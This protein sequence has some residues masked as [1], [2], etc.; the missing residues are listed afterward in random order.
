LEYIREEH[1][2]HLDKLHESHKQELVEIDTRSK[3]LKK[4]L[5]KRDDQLMR[6]KEELAES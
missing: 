4:L 6:V 2:E 3:K 5:E 1:R